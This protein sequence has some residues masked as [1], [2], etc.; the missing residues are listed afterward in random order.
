MKNQFDKYWGLGGC[1]DYS[2]FVLKYNLH[3]LPWLINFHKCD[4]EDKGINKHINQVKYIYTNNIKRQTCVTVHIANT[5][6]IQD[7]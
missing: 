1:T 5:H 2:H 3:T 4:F 7:E 6:S